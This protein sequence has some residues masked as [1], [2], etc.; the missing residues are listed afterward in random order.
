MGNASQYTA[1]GRSLAKSLMVNVELALTYAGLASTSEDSA[2]RRSFQTKARREYDYISC[3]LAES[4]STL[5]PSDSVTIETALAELKE[6]LRR[7]G[8]TFERCP[9]EA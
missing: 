7:L 5:F 3:L 2:V 6:K 8:E 4:F 9:P 1:S